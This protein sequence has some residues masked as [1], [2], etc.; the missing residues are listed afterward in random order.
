[1]NES[2]GRSDLIDGEVRKNNVVVAS[3]DEGDYEANKN[4]AEACPV[5]IIKFN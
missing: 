1:M 5:N 3:I 4:A 2:D